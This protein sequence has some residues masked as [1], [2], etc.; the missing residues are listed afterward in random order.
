MANTKGRDKRN[1][2]AAEAVRAFADAGT[3][4]ARLRD[5]IPDRE[6]IDDIDMAGRTRGDGLVVLR[7]LL[8]ILARSGRVFAHQDDVML[9][10]RANSKF[11]LL[12]V[13]GRAEPK[14]GARLSDIVAGVQIKKD[15]SGEEN[16]WEFKLP[17]SICDQL[18]AMSGCTTGLPAV[19]IYA[20]HSVFDA[21]FVL[22]GPGYHPEHE[23]S[24][25]H[26]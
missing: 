2:A 5:D 25:I 8:G 20:S 22:H 11:R 19:R 15:K 21:D 4:L 16:C 9:T 23:L 13:D 6:V 18:F 26:I 12:S 10:D 17:D 14:A 24:L 7:K 3:A 1:T